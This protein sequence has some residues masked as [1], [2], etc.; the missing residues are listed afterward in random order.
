MPMY[1]LVLFAFLQSPSAVVPVRSGCSRDTEQIASVGTGDR[2]EV[3]MAMAGEDE[4]CYKITLVRPEG[5]LTGYVLGNSLPAVA[6]FVRR[7][8]KISQESAAEEARLLLARSA[9][10]KVDEKA[11][12]KPVDPFISTQFEEFSGRDAHGK[13]VS[14]SGLQG[15]VFVVS[16]WSPKSAQS[17]N[18]LTSVM[19]L[20]NQFHKSGLAAVGVSVDPNPDHILAGLDDVSPA[21]PQVADGSGLAAHYGVDP[22]AGKTFV[23]DASHRVVAAGQMGPEMEKTIRELMSK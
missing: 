17:Q 2:V 14:L 4:T 11:I 1:T 6:A 7:R 22:K 3:G 21:W 10:P 9:A 18:Q 23:L 5:N 8:E 19:P 15:R 20:Y 13:S 16:F 12:S